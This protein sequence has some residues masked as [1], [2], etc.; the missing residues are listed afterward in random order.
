MVLKLRIPM[1]LKLRIP[2]VLK[3]R[4]PLVLKMRIPVV[5]KLRI[6]MVLK[7]SILMALKLRI[8]MVLKLRILTVLQLR[9]TMVLKLRI[10][11][12]QQQAI[13]NRKQWA[14]RPRSWIFTDGRGLS[15]VHLG[16][17]SE[18]DAS[19]PKRRWSHLEAILGYLESIASLPLA[20]LFPS[21]T[22]SIS[23]VTEPGI[24]FLL[25][26][27]AYLSHRASCVL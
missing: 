24:K 7:L 21:I 8:P 26:H 22:P 10:S 2:M 15:W 16:A 19:P 20:L 14:H 1:V 25:S 6:P 23:T 18:M 17:T 12:V 11:M 27:Q 9:I 5:L 4:T 3:L 13:S